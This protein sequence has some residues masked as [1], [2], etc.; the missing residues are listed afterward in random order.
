[1][2]GITT[3]VIRGRGERGEGEGEQGQRGRVIAQSG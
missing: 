3:R 1:M 2:E